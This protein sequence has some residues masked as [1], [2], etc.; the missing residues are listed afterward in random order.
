MWKIALV[1][2]FVSACTHEAEAVASGP[3]FGAVRV[4]RADPAIASQLGS[5]EKV[6]VTARDAILAAERA[7]PRARVTDIGFDHALGR[8]LYLVSMHRNGEAWEVEVDTASMAVRRTREGQTPPAEESARTSA[9]EL[10]DI[11]LIE[12]IAVGERAGGGKAVSASL[13]FAE[14]RLVFRVV[15]LAAGYLKQVVIDPTDEARRRRGS[16]RWRHD[17]EVWKID[18]ILQAPVRIR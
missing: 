6:G 16:G 11:D 18:A 15:V 13:D 1:L 4:D 10:L 3:A 8:P 9:F 2:L 17:P 7:Y 12:A 14:G 5:F